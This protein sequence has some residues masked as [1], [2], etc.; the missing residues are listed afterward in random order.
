MTDSILWQL[1]YI[2]PNDV[3]CV[4]TGSAPSA[5]AR[6]DG[7]SSQSGARSTTPSNSISRFTSCSELN[8]HENQIH[9]F[10]HGF[11]Q[12]FCGCY[13]SFWI[14]VKVMADGNVFGSVCQYLSLLLPTMH[15]KGKL[16]IPAQGQAIFCFLLVGSQVFNYGTFTEA[17]SGGIKTRWSPVITVHTSLDLGSR[18]RKQ[19]NHSSWHVKPPECFINLFTLC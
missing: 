18:E 16:L 12:E 15:G 13:C 17:V 14:I 5:A 11:D 8:L 10:S 2:S 1:M 4:R 9:K 19:Q 7:G 3:R 6:A